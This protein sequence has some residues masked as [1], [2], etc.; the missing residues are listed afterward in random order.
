MCSLT[1]VAALVPF[2]F[3]VLLEAP[4]AE[5]AAARGACSFTA[6]E[7]AYTEEGAVYACGRAMPVVQTT[8][9]ASV[10]SKGGHVS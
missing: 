3:C 5:P 8:V 10:Q 7:A 2:C 6:T 1:H 4:A 9:S